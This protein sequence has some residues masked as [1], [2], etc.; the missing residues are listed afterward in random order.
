MAFPQNDSSAIEAGGV[1]GSTLRHYR[2]I[3]HTSR[4]N[5]DHSDH[6]DTDESNKST[7]SVKWEVHERVYVRGEFPPPS[8]AA[9]LGYNLADISA[10]LATLVRHNESYEEGVSLAAAEARARG[11]SSTAV[12]G[13]NRFTSGS[14][15]TRGRVPAT[16][17]VLSAESVFELSVD[18]VGRMTAFKVRLV[19]CECV[20]RG[21]SFG[22]CVDK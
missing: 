20:D 6:R 9:R 5:N 16:P 15:S 22:N 2:V 14:R 19:A 1:D 4:P 8:V 3:Y 12:N 11:S 18:G 13:Q 21:R 17:E 7:S 10:T